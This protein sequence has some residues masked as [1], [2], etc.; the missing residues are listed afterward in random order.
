MGGSV[1]LS[2]RQQSRRSLTPA[3]ARAPGES[4]SPIHLRLRV[5]FRFAQSDSE[6][7]SEATQ[8]CFMGVKGGAPLPTKVGFPAHPARTDGPLL[9]P[10]RFPLLALKPSRPVPTARYKKRRGPTQ[11]GG[12]SGS[13]GGAATP[14]GQRPMAAVIVLLQEEKSLSHN[15]P[16]PPKLKCMSDGNKL[17]K[18]SSSFMTVGSERHK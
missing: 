8:A 15:R 17:I 1:A 13:V 9:D 3:L 18:D 4:L 7:G 14:S 16:P 2:N 10:G 11:N 6:S 12:Q 5:Y